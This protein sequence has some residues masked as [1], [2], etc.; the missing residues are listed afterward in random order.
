MF[1]SCR[2]C[3]TKRIILISGPTDLFRI[4]EFNDLNHHE[5]LQENYHGQTAVFMYTVAIKIEVIYQY[6]L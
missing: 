1:V 2:F 3:K 6:C 5:K 4:F